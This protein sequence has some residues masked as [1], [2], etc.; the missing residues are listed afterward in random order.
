[1]W[2]LADVS[3]ENARELSLVGDKQATQ[4]TGSAT[5][6]GRTKKRGK[7]GQRLVAAVV[8][9]IAVATV[10]AAAAVLLLGC[11]GALNGG[12]VGP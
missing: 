12:A 5:E 1:L 2:G 8:A 10:V 11:G 7:A 3:A 9:A 4:R 6:R